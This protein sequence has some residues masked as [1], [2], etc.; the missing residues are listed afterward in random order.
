MLLNLLKQVIEVYMNKLES[1]N[2]AP[3]IADI[4]FDSDEKFEIEKSL[5]NKA[6][7]FIKSHTG[8]G[9]KLVKAMIKGNMIELTLR[10]PFYCY[11]NISL[12]KNKS[13]ASMVN[14]N[15]QT[16]YNDYKSELENLVSSEIGRVAR[17][18]DIS[19][20]VAEN[21]ESPLFY[22]IAE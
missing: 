6:A 4:I 8:K 13:N 10:E 11:V 1:R 18:T 21:R 2:S 12:L 16:F 14:Y 9:P 15:R 17:L 3:V 5:Q 22:Y 7:F 20:L 19:I